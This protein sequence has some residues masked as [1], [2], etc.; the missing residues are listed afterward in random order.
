M[1]PASPQVRLQAEVAQALAWG[2][3]V[4]ALE[5]TLI[6]HG[7]PRPDNLELAR[8]LEQIVRDEGAVPATV[9]VI[10]GVPTIG[11]TPDEIERIA[12]VDVPKLS[13][14]DLAAA[15][16]SGLD[17]ATTVASTAFLAAQTGIRLFATGGLGGV[18]REA[19][20]TWDESADLSTLSHTPI[21]IVCAGVKSILDVGATLERLE[22]LNVAVIGYGTRQFPGFYLADSGFALDWSVDTPDAAAEIM[23]AQVG[24]GL[25]RSGIVFGNPIPLAEQLDPAVHERVLAAGLAEVQRRGLRGKGVTPFL[26]EYFRTET[27]GASVLVNKQLVRN[28]ARVAARIAS[29][30]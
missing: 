20:E 9:G 1:P 10:R 27:G 4:V 19:R 16:A 23:R 11:L 7:L 2:R 14:R 5:S 6:A 18:H 8:E 28:N 12:T 13:V 15:T 24:I 3:P 21:A 26:L 22:S 30:L 29:A 25:E 17:G